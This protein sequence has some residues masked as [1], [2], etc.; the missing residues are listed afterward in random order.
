MIL[1][2]LNNNQK[3]FAVLIDPDK[4]SELSLLQ[5]ILKINQSAANL[6]LV[7][8]SLVKSD[9]ERTVQLLKA[10]TSLPIVL[11]PGNVSQ[12]TRHIDACL[13]LSLISGRNPEYLISSHVQAAPFLKRHNIETVSTG[14]ILID[15]GV[16]T[17]V[18][19]VS[20]TKPIPSDKTE[21]VVATAM[22]AELIGMH[23]VYLES[24]SGAK[25]SVQPALVAEVKAAIDIPVI[26]GGGVKDARNMMQLY[27]AGADMVV[28]GNAFEDNPELIHEFG[29]VV[30]KK[31]S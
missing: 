28:V 4:H 30:D 12:L 6:V 11:F 29:L 5:T 16:T 23:C 10:E 3:K 22:A 15:G 8:G 14:Y 26:V 25:H 2:L 31:Y 21:L 27:E 18:E 19:Y 17:S 20:N 24:G 9:M 7:G 13:F 1:D